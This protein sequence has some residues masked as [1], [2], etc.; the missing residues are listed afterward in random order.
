MVSKLVPYFNGNNWRIEYK[1]GLAYGWNVLSD[2]FSRLIFGFQVVPHFC[3][4][5]K[6]LPLHV[7]LPQPFLR[8]LP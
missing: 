6:S 4:V 5:P 3:V 1:K 7:E 8:A 2:F